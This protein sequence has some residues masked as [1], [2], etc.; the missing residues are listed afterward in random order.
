MSFDLLPKKSFIF[1]RLEH[2]ALEV[3]DPELQVKV[4]SKSNKLLGFFQPEGSLVIH[5]WGYIPV[6]A[7]KFNSEELGEIKTV[8][9][10][11]NS[12]ATTRRF[13]TQIEML[14]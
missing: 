12:N 1:P 5:N 13:N 10:Y 3:Q 4:T 2:I 9:D 8:L 14:K 7:L 6:H 11:L